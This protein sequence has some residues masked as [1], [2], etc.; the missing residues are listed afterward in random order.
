MNKV[1]TSSESVGTDQAGLPTFLLVIIGQLQET[2]QSVRQ[3]TAGGALHQITSQ[4]V[5]IGGVVYLREG[6]VYLQVCAVTL[7]QV[8]VF[9]LPCRPTN[10]MTLFFPLVGVQAFT[11]GS[12][13]W[14][15]SK[16]TLQLIPERIFTTV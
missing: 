7:E 3:Q 8:V 4:L 6:G 13:S 10:M 12:T 1:F 14:K 9:P 15:H 16:H 11:P 2:K 5:D